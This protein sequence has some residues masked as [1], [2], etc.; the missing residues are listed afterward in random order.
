MKKVFA[1][2]CVI[3]AVLTS[4]SSSTSETSTTEEEPIKSGVVYR[5]FKNNKQ[6]NSSLHILLEDGVI[7]TVNANEFSEADIA[8]FVQPKDTIFYQG[9]TIKEVH[10]YKQ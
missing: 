10:F 4:C 8:L 2:V 6:F 7:R 1:L 5:T 9:R 3:A